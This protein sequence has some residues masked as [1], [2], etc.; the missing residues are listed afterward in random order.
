MCYIL[1]PS[2][3]ASSCSPT[4]GT[5]GWD[6]SGGDRWQRALALAL[7]SRPPGIP[8][9]LDREEQAYAHFVSS[10]NKLFKAGRMAQQVKS[11]LQRPNDPSSWNCVKTEKENQLHKVVL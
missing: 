5:A 11:Q 10:I 8:G 3:S 2:N 9:N 4:A 7:W 1:S 6:A